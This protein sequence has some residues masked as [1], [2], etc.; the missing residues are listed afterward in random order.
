M[1]FR[2]EI[3]AKKADFELLPGEN[4][5]LAGSCFAENIGKKLGDYGFQTSINPMGIIFNPVSLAKIINN[6]LSEAFQINNDHIIERESL[7]FSLDFHSKL[8]ANDPQKLLFEITNRLSNLREAVTEAKTI[9]IT[10]GTAYIYRYQPTNNIVANCQKIPQTY[11][12]KS[13]LEVDEI[14]ESWN[15]TVKSIKAVNPNCK[16]VFT[17]SPVRHI[18]DGFHENQLSKSTLLLAINKLVE[19]N[20]FCSYYPAYELL[21]DD[22]RDYRFYSEDLIHPNDQAVEYVR[23]HFWETYLSEKT[24]QLVGKYEKIK[25][26]LEH[27]PL[28]RGNQH[29]TFLKETKKML[30]VLNEQFP[31][32]NLIEEVDY[33]LKKYE[34]RAH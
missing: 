23:E 16:I 30:L 6:S 32:E 15:Y 12:T 18:K 31:V 13:L 8:Y 9:F 20:D 11:F 25:R 17:V 22:L 1:K 34:Q 27:R 2:T 24:I 7:Y 3:K 26:R 14:T 28:Q 5:L 21:L 29:L 4:I 19:E 10:F 33:K